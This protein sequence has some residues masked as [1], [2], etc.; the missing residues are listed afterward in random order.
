MVNVTWGGDHKMLV[1]YY[2]GG[3]TTSMS[4][5]SVIDPWDGTT[6]SLSS[7]TATRWRKLQ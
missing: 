3:S 1:Y 5:Y 4:S 2:N 7:Y 6:K